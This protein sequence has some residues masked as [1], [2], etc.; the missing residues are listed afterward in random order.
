M[1][2][3]ILFGPISIILNNCHSLLVH[4]LFC[5]YETVWAGPQY[6]GSLGFNKGKDLTREQLE[7]TKKVTEEKI[8]CIPKEKKPIYNVK[9]KKIPCLG[10]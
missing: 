2:N 8:P 5:S 4:H 6:L 1:K 9:K 10:H 3:T 7:G